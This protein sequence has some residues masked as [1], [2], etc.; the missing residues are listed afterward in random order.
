ML[1]SE[2]IKKCQELEI[3]HGDLEIAILDGFNGGG[4]PRTINSPPRVFDTSKPCNYFCEDDDDDIFFMKCYSIL[5][6]PL[7]PSILYIHLHSNSIKNSI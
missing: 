3:L 5:S 6:L 1:L 2:M 7:T 4:V